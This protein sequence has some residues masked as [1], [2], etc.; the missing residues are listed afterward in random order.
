MSL[1]I[2]DLDNTLI[3][4]D[5]DYAWGEFLVEIGVVSEQAYRAA[6][7][8]FYEDYK[9]GQL[10][11][12]EYLDFALAPLAQHPL[13]ALHD[14]RHRFL[15]EKVTPMFLPKAEALVDQHRQRGDTVLIITATNRFVTE[16]IAEA[17]GIPNLIA[18]EPEFRDGRYTGHVAGTPSF[19]DGKIKRLDQWLSQREEDTAG[20]WF[21][22]DSH[23][24]L[25]LLEQVDNPVGV[26]PDEALRRV[27]EQ[28]GW[29]IMSLRD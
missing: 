17:L 15:T 8:R 19:Q 20:A 12:F 25:P 24:D 1:A 2:F 5:S 13:E 10:D 27:C 6:N 23:N 11:I 29:P 16:P 26:D 14:W 3:G 22:S 18:T 4:G 28:R 7:T 9:A 21:Y